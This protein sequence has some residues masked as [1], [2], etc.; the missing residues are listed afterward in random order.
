MLF[1]IFDKWKKSKAMT[2]GE[3]Y[4]LKKLLSKENPN[5][6]ILLSQATEAPFI[7][8]KKIGVNGYEATIP[9]VKDESMLIEC[10]DDIESPALEL[11]LKS[12]L[13]LAFST[14]ILRGG[15]LFG[16]IGNCVNKDFWEKNWENEFL[17]MD[18]HFEIQN[19]FP[20]PMAHT[21][22]NRKI[23]LLFSW[24]VLPISEKYFHKSNSFRMTVSAID[25][26]I[27]NCEARLGVKLCAN[28]REL[29]SI[30]NGL[31]VNNDFFF[32]IFGTKDAY[33]FDNDHKW[34]IIG[35]E[36]EESF[37]ALKCEK[38]IMS[39]N[40][41]MLSP[42]VKNN[43]LGDLKDYIREKLVLAFSQ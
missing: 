6:A 12:G 35:C 23:Q 36:N 31:G 38:G 26:E 15:F 32:E 42:S 9:F 14:K 3:L 1:G 2:L 28:Y 4:V 30:T 41:Y 21:E 19:W 18:S 24:C 43:F 5:S 33:F 17:E 27:Q 34:V 11:K 29:L 7:V 16:L 20:Y 22:V 39:D 10:D 37:I 13:I 8:R 25:S 40:C